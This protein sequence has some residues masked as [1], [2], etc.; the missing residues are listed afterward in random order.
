MTHTEHILIG[1]IIGG[2]LVLWRVASDGLAQMAT[3]RASQKEV[4]QAIAETE[5]EQAE[6]AEETEELRNELGASITELE[7]LTNEYNRL[8]SIRRK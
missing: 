8:N 5:R 1:L 7:N 4:D 6:T 2:V 3:L